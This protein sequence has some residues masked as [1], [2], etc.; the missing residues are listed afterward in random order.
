MK[1]IVSTSSLLKNLQT[2]SGVISTTSVLPIL[3]EGL[4]KQTS[5]IGDFRCWGNLP[6]CQGDDPL[7]L[8][9]EVIKEKGKDRAKIGIELDL[10]Q[11]MGMNLAQFDELK[12]SL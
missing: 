1:F 4:G 8:I 6:G 3:E 12:A 10:G 2:L 9:A 7:S 5:Y 11:R